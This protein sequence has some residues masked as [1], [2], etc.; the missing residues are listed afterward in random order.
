MLKK[1]IG[2]KWTLEAKKYFELVKLA[3][4]Q[5]PILI[6]PNFTKELYIL[7]FALEHIVAVVLFQKNMMGNNNP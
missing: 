7:S 3:L 1:E 5:T 6:S 2:V 4:T